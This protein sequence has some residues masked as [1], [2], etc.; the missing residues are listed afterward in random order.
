MPIDEKEAEY[1]RAHRQHAIPQHIGAFQ[2]KLVGQ[3]TIRQFAYIGGF[4]VLAWVVIASGLPAIIRW[5]VA[6]LVFAAG[7]ALAFVPVAGRPLDKMIVAFL[8]A[9]LNPTQRVWIK[10]GELPEF[11]KPEFGKPKIG[12]PTPKTSASRKALEEYL[13]QFQPS[14][15]QVDLAETAFISRLDFGVTL[16]AKVARASQRAAK[17]K[18][19]AEEKT[20]PGITVE[21]RQPIKKAVVPLASAVNFVERPVITIPSPRPA[22]QPPTF[23]SSIGEVKVRKLRSRP[24][25]TGGLT[26]KVRGEKKFEISPELKQRLGLETKDLNLEGKTKA[27]AQVSLTDLKK[28]KNGNLKQEVVGPKTATVSPLAPP[29]VPN[30]ISGVVKDA[31]GHLLEDVI[32]IVKNEQGAPVRAL[33]TNLLGQFSISTPLPSEKYQI[34]PEREGHKFSIIEFEAQGTILQPIE[35]VAQK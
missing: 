7:V 3:L 29:T 33:K 12:P 30:I 13:T 26:V 2:F 5:P 16:P 28:Q 1:L 31:A 14:P 25:L 4:A 22:I 19:E 24:N 15:S 23:L 8:R 32:L 27:E 11:F 10:K 20:L 18:P 34:L 21:E 35:I 6:S 17:V 9:V